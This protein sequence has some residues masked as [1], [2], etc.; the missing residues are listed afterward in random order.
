MRRKKERGFQFPFCQPH[1]LTHV[2]NHWA[3]G[4]LGI[5]PPESG[6][7]GPFLVTGMSSPS[8]PPHTLQSCLRMLTLPHHFLCERLWPPQLELMS[9]ITWFLSYFEHTFFKTLIML[10]IIVGFYQVPRGQ[11]LCPFY[12]YTF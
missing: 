3:Y 12:L 10:G 1:P 4:K 8:L 11:G 7:F 5:C 9:F 6:A 2:P